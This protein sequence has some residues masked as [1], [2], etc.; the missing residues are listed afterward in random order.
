M[1]EY[2]TD[3]LPG[4]I[5]QCLREAPESLCIYPKGNKGTVEVAYLLVVLWLL[6]FSFG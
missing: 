5:K 4:S 6:I 2:V 1:P 3:Y